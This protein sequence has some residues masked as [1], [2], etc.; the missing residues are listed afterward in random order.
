MPKT[1]TKDGTSRRRPEQAADLG[2]T[3]GA[4]EVQAEQEEIDD[5]APREATPTVT[6]ELR[7][8]V[9]E[10]AIEVLRPVARKA[11]TSAAKYAVTRGPDMV[12]D[13]V[14]PMVSE[15]GG[16]GSLVKGVVSKGGDVAGGITGKLG[17]AGK[18][19]KRRAAEATGRGRRL[20]VQEDIDV[21]VPIEVAY[22]QWTQF[23]EFPR[24]M[25]RVEKLEQ[26]DDTTLMWHEN[27]WG[28]RRSWEAEITEQ[29]PCR[30]IAWRSK[31]GPNVVG[32]VTF[33]ELSE[34]LT[35]IQVNLD[36]QPKGFFEKA[37]S[38][39]RLSRRALKSDLMRF[40]AFIEMRDEPTGAWTGRIEEGEVVE[41]GRA[42]GRKRREP[43]E[44]EERAEPEERED[45]E[46]ADEVD[47]E[48][49]AE[50]APDEEEDYE[51]EEDEEE[52][53]EAKPVRRRPTS[54]PARRRSRR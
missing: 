37:A 2:P 1:G 31:G 30:R 19:K 33:H 29:T 6:S 20:P 54:A 14:K 16:A 22:A 51:E 44:P 11:T 50:V 28:V 18:G 24:F 48:P 35:R 53:A 21:G 26:R 38:G 23:E 5:V 7:D 40:K 39:M 8:A 49:E 42:R 25:H 46:F 47:E 3:D 36:F 34:T 43:E 13:K 52:P 4:P 17:L 45:E 27:I 32:V 15:A 9:R 10:A 12:K 41:E